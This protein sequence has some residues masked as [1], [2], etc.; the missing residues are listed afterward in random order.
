VIEII[1]NQSPTQF[2]GS[3]RIH[4]P[5]IVGNAD[6]SSAQLFHQPAPLGDDIFHAAG[7]PGVAGD[8]LGA[9]GTLIR[10]PPRGD[11]GV[12]AGFRVQAI[13]EGIKVGVALDFEEVMG[14][15]G[16]GIQVFAERAIQIVLNFA[17][18]V[19]PGEAQNMA[20]IFPA[21]EARFVAPLLESPVFFQRG[22]DLDDRLLRFTAHD[23]VNRLFLHR[24]VGHQGQMRAAQNSNSTALFGDGRRFPGA[25][26]QR[27]G[28]RNSNHIVGIAA[29]EG[30]KTFK[31][32]LDGSVPNIHF[33]AARQ[34]RTG[35]VAQSHV[36]MFSAVPYAGF[37]AGE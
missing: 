2:F 9:V 36:N 20:H 12:G 37:R 3:N 11:D 17:V 16:D 19:A 29:Q 1:V 5:N 25:D 6:F 15:K 32:F 34:Q 33:I 23:Q 22:D 4:I 18:F 7:P 21:E 27:R 31:L 26:N 30:V 35:Q 24:F 8:R 14:R 10:T 28:R 13:G